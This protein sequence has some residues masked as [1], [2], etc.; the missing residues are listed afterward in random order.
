MATATRRVVRTMPQM[1][2][3]VVDDQPERLPVAAYAR[4]ST[5]KE[6][7]E[8]S[9]ERQVEHYKQMIYSKPEWQFVDVYADPGISGTRAEKRP[10][11][12]RMIEDCRAGKIKKVLV[13]SISRFARNTVDAL[14]YIR[15]LKDLGISVY[16]ESENIDTLTP[17]GEV[18]LTILAA[19]AEQESRTISSN[20]KWAFQRRF[21]AG[22]VLLNTGMML[23]YRK[24]GKD[25]NGHDVY[26]IHEEEADTVRRIFREYVAGITVTQIC[27]RL[28]ADGILTKTGKEKWYPSVILSII[29]NEKYTGNA[30]LGKTFKPDVLTKARMKNDGVKAPMYYVEN[31]HPAIVSMELF[32]QAQAETQHRNSSRDNAVGSSRYTSKYPFSGLLVCGLCGSKLRRHVRTVGTGDHV[33]AWGCSLRIKEGRQECDLRHVR[34]DVLCQTYIAAMQQLLGSAEEVV[35]AVKDGACL[36][37]E[38]GNREELQSVEE[39][40]IQTQEAVL[41]AHKQKVARKITPSEYDAEIAQLK[42][43]M[44][45]LEARQVE[46]KQQSIGYAEVRVWLEAFERQLS[47]NDA[48]GMLDPVL[49]KTL[50]DQIIVNQ[51]GIRVQFKCGSAV[52]QEFVT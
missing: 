40:I 28:K 9:F 43:A 36:A 48:S 37:L 27:R 3:D 39:Q 33:P 16:F 17:G 29:S 21:Q 23:G 10:D 5:E 41:K 50:V 8:D 30:Y 14:Q 12:L 1:F 2:I 24:T 38:P 35:E 32:Q 7:Q 18:L 42:A 20:I 4:V 46:L 47:S 25:E 15:E 22:N 44:K 34:E 6:E 19:M 45:Q 26:E 51:T 52:E 13:K 49:L 11:F 31:T